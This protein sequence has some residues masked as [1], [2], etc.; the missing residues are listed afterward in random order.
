MAG[1]THAGYG[2]TLR[3]ICFKIPRRNE[4]VVKILGHGYPLRSRCNA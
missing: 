1:I 4:T 2:W 3:K